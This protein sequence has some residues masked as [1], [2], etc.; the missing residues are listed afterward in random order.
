MFIEFVDSY[1]KFLMYS[2]NATCPQITPPI[3]HTNA[4]KVSFVTFA[5]FKKLAKE[6]AVYKAR[7]ALM[8]VGVLCKKMFG[9]LCKKMF[10]VF[11]LFI[12]LEFRFFCPF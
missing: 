2:L 7:V 8:F 9:V 5:A 11:L 3:D 1:F 4:N 10:G 12:F 6:A